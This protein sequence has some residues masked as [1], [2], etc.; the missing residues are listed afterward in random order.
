MNIIRFF[1]LP[2]LLRPIR[3][4]S[5]PNNGF[6]ACCG[7]KSLVLLKN[8]SKV[9]YV[10][11]HVIKNLQKENGFLRNIFSRIPF[12]NIHKMRLQAYG[13]VLYEGIADK[14]EYVSFFDTYDLPDTFY[15]WFVVTELYIWMLSVRFMADGE[16][17]T[18][19]RN[20]LIEALW[21]DVGQRVRKLGAG[22]PS[23]VRQDIEELSEQLQAALISYDEG[24]QSN[25]TV[26]AGAL[27]RRL[28]QMGPV[29]LHNLDKLVEY[30][31]KQIVL[32]DNV[33][34]DQIFKD[35]KVKW[36]PTT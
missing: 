27:W 17:G 4:I 12:L 30:V 10:S 3:V 2:S 29:H 31:R 33:S 16:D 36:E 22:N 14:V 32:L 6:H 26:L 11:T 24:L 35:K 28:Y 7:V 34:S 13:F 23:A 9:Q 19:I 18:V 25:D 1:N 15:S 8:T 21:K 5:V 20:A